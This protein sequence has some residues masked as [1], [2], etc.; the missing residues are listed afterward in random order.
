MV[1]VVPELSLT[2]AMTGGNYNQG[3]IWG[4]WRDDIIGSLIIPAVK[5]K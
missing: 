1:V 3:F 5:G 2:V 4:R